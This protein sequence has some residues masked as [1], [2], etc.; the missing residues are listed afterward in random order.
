MT[1]A[2]QKLNIAQPPLS[3][4]IQ[5]LE[6]ELGIALIERTSRPLR[7]TEAGRLFHEQAVQILDRINEVS[8]LMQRMRA[9]ERNRFGL[10]FAASMLY[11]NLPEVIRIY[12]T[13]RSAVDLALLELTTIEQFAALKDRRIDVGVGRLEVDDPSIEQTLLRNEEL[14][15]AV[16]S[17]LAGLACGRG[18]RLRDLAGHTLILYPKAPRPS[19]ADQVLSFYRDRGLPVRGMIEVRELQTAL[20]LVAAEA[21]ICIVPRSVERLC[22]DNVT[23]KALEDGNLASPVIMSIRKGDRSAEIDYILQIIREVYRKVGVTFGA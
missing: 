5:H 1:R 12:R 3:R 9:V 16:P 20:G 23:Y 14:V 19:Y 8:A 7:L 22:R 11:S 10:G 2:A 18:M 13:T 21:G 17:T 15:V 4:Q 6:Q